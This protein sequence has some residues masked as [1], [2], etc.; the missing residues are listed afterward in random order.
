MPINVGQAYLVLATDNPNNYEVD[1]VTTDGMNIIKFDY[2]TRQHYWVS[3]LSSNGLTFARDI[4]LNP[5]VAGEL[6]LQLALQALTAVR[7]GESKLITQA[8]LSVAAIVAI[9]PTSTG[10]YRDIEV[11]NNEGELINPDTIVVTAL[12]IAIGLETYVP[13]IGTYKILYRIEQI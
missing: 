13:I 12:G 9:I 11:Y 6:D 10:I 2:Y 1:T 7:G 4:V 5:P 8:D 3:R